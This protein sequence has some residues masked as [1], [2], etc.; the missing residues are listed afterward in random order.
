MPGTGQADLAPLRFGQTPAQP[1]R[2]AMMYQ[3]SQQTQPAEGGKDPD[4]VVL[5][6]FDDHRHRFT[7]YITQNTHH[8]G[9]D[10]PTNRIQDGKAQWAEATAAYD[11]WRDA[12]DTVEEAKTKHQRDLVALQQPMGP[13]CSHLPMGTPGDQALPLEAAQVEKEL[14]SQEGADKGNNDHPGQLQV[15][16]VGQK[17]RND[18]YGLAF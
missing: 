15:T 4:L 6:I 17:A 5:D 2:A 11:E 9:P 8:I 16:T 10:Q 3:P 1:R 18:Q 7:E 12:A 14:I 13:L